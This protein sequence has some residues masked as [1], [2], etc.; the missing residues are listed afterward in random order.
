MEIVQ[1]EGGREVTRAVE[2]Y[3]LDAIIAVGY[4]VNSYQATQFRI[5]ATERLREYLV[6]G[7]ALDDARLKRGGGGRV[8]RRD[9][10]A[11]PRHTVVEF[12]RESRGDRRVQ[13]ARGAARCVQRRV[14]IVL[15][16]Q[17]APRAMPGARLLRHADQ[18]PVPRLAHDGALEAE[19]TC[20]LL[21]PERTGS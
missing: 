21:E 18:L 13:P 16:M 10:R 8:L 14:A 7:F 5:W 19:A 12:G 2:F 9:A 11:D 17:S 20:V 15:S 3:N 4:R 6:K 1:P